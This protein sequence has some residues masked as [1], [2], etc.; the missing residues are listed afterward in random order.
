MADLSQKERQQLEL[1]TS[2]WNTIEDLV[3][4]LEQV[5]EATTC[6]GEENYATM[7]WLLPLL[8]GLRKTCTTAADGSPGLVV[9]KK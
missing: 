5:D 6:L 3:D 9:I 7:S 8:C 1:S 2:Q 4:L